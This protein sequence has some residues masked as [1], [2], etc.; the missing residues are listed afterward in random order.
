MCLL[1]VHALTF[2]LV[3]AAPCPRLLLCGAQAR[4][5]PSHSIIH[6]EGDAANSV[7]FLVSGEVTQVVAGPA[8]PS[9]R[10]SL[11]EGRSGSSHKQSMEAR[12]GSRALYEDLASGSGNLST[13]TLFLFQGKT[14]VAGAGSSSA[15]ASA[16]DAKAGAAGGV[17][18]AASDADGMNGGKAAEEGAKRG[19]EAA[20]K[21]E[22]AA[23]AAAAGTAAAAGP[24]GGSSDG[25]AQR[26]VRRARHMLSSPAYQKR[27]L[28][29]PG[30]AFGN[31]G[32]SLGLPSTQKDKDKE[33]RGPKEIVTA[34]VTSA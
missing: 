28:L 34:I 21:E 20:E 22:A 10:H 26:E 25:S 14:V 30:Q 8:L 23:Q 15:A 2:N 6:N 9:H 1:C 11:L 31:A 27:S 18:A 4:K 32:S 33:R 16:G 12:A 24:N 29:L 7:Y 17:S 19:A 3:A 13:N 5:L